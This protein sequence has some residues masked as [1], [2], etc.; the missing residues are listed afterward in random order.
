MRSFRSRVHISF[1]SRNPGF[2][3][4]CETGPPT[5][6][7]VSGQSG[8]TGP[9]PICIG[10]DVD[11]VK[12]AGTSRRPTKSSSV[13]SPTKYPMCTLCPQTT[14]DVGSDV[15]VHSIRKSCHKGHNDV[16]RSAECPIQGAMLRSPSLPNA[17][18]LHYLVSA[19]STAQF[20]IPPDAPQ[21]L[22]LSKATRNSSTT[23]ATCS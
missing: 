21:N 11:V 17:L 4:N 14:A 19:R 9:M 1:K 8:D 15:T 7:E 5:D 12:R 16:P 6:E 23:V 18:E 2:G 22:H 10:E 20:S 13:R 3:L